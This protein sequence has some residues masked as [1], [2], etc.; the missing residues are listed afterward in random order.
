[1]V[2]VLAAALIG[3]L[4]LYSRGDF[5][6]PDDAAL[7]SI[8][9]DTGEVVMVAVFGAASLWMIFFFHG[10][11][12]FMLCS[13]VSIWYF[14]DSKGESGAPCCD[15]LW[16]LFRYHSGSVAFGSLLN[17]LLFVVRIIIHI[18]SFEAK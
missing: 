3:L 9:L 14:K 5:S 8:S 16:R 15:S 6:F 2:A 18:L 17:G 7:P 11:N 13:S 4:Y 1:M 12:H 10:C